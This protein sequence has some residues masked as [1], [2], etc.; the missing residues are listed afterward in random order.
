MG[1]QVRKKKTPEQIAAEA[2]SEE[3]LEKAKT[4]ANQ[5]A[6][7]VM[8]FLTWDEWEEHA[9]YA[10]WDDARISPE[11]PIGQDAET[12]RKLSGYVFLAM[13]FKP[14]T[15]ASAWFGGEQ[16]SELVEVKA[17][18]VH[19]YS[20]DT[21]GD[22]RRFETSKM[23]ENGIRWLPEYAQEALDTICQI[24]S[25]ERTGMTIGRF[26]VAEIDPSDR[27]L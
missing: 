18:G 4:I 10:D 14:S 26:A 20:N 21:S 27:Y 7:V 25:A 17:V 19:I 6:D 24:A 13:Q 2:H 9:T 15:K 3:Q 23:W 16:S 22:N 5:A 8:G 12:G 1:E 11:M